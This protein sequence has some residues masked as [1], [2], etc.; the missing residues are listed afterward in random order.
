MYLSV[1]NQKPFALE[2]NQSRK[3]FKN[4][5]ELRTDF[6]LS[7][8]QRVALNVYV[9]SLRRNDRH[10]LIRVQSVLCDVYKAM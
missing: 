4:V 1:R 10:T 8:D 3:S 6:A 7:K 9:V 2:N 5:K